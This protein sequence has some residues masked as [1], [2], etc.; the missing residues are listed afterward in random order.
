[1]CTG[2]KGVLGVF[3]VC[4]WCQ[5]RLKLSC[6]VDECKPLVHLPPQPERFW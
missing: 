5:T 2:F 4:S 3:M 6:E 1:V